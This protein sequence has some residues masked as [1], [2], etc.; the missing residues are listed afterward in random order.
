[1]T[2]DESYSR[3]LAAI[4]VLEEAVIEIGRSLPVERQKAVLAR[5]EALRQNAVTADSPYGLSIQE[6]ADRIGRGLS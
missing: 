5:M 1:M 3:L 2:D 6:T 4:T